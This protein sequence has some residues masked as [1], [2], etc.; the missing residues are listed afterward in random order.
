M[1]NLHRKSDNHFV[2]ACCRTIHLR[3]ISFYFPLDICRSLHSRSNPSTVLGALLCGVLYHPPT[4]TRRLHFKVSLGCPPNRFYSVL[5]L[6]VCAGPAKFPFSSLSSSSSSA[7]SCCV[8][9]ALLWWL[10]NELPTAF[11]YCQMFCAVK[12]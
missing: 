7:R 5:S 2:A 3:F 10:L 12:T 8:H 4:Y 11:S 1:G 9:P 6:R